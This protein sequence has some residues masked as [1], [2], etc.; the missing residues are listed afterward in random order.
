VL[1][2]REIYRLDLQSTPERYG[3]DVRYLDAMLKSW[4]WEALR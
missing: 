3:Q 4:R 1:R 2:N